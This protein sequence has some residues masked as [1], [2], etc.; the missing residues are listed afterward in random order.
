MSEVKLTP[1]DAMIEM[2][3]VLVEEAAAVAEAAD[4]LDERDADRAVAMILACAGR[5]VVTGMG[6]SGA[7]GR[8]FAG[9]LASTG[10]PSIFLHPAEAIHGD[11]GMVVPGDVVAAFSYSGETD[12][13]LKLLAPIISLGVGIIAFTGRVASTLGRASKVVM[14]VSVE[15]EA[16]FMNLAPTTSTTLML[17][18]SDAL[19][20]AVMKARGFTSEDYA[21]RHPGGTLGRRL[22]LSVRDVMRTGDNVAIVTEKTSLFDTMFEITRA[23][24]GAAIVVDGDGKVTGLLTDGDVRRHLIEDRDC[25]ERPVSLSMNNRPGV[26]TPDILAVEG[27]RLLEKFHPEPGA[28]AGEAPVVDDDMRPVGMLNLKDLVKAGFA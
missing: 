2:R 7:V 21:R 10:T 27:L 18:M 19:S 3:R 4:R 20:M 5:V 22:L 26:A 9:T 13:L 28:R 11:L 8:K 12:E 23:H 1:G 24:A 16:C 15:R 25:L 14:D 6:K 17:A